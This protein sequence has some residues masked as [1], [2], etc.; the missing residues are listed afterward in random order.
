MRAVAA[1]LGGLALLGGC[2]INRPRADIAYNPATFT[3]PDTQYATTAQGYRLGPLD[4]VHLNVFEVPELTGDYAISEVGKIDLP[5]VGGIDAQNITASD[6]AGKL[7]AVLSQKYF[8][9]PNVTVTIKEVHSQRVT[10]DGAV[11]APG[12]YPVSGKL[13]LLQSVAM[14]KGLS[15]S[16]NA[17]RVVVFRTIEGRRAAAAFDLNRVREGITPD[18]LV[19]GNDIVVVDGSRSRS[20]LRDVVRTLPLLALFRFL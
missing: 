12:V 2:A 3:E 7:K 6:L 17:G 5:L 14:A 18:P 20:A 19:Y 1:A 8:Q 13:T 9:D 4:V 10:V 11:N 16:A 15:E